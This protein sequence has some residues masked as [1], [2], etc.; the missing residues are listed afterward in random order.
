[1]VGEVKV[2]G[3]ITIFK[4][5]IPERYHPQASLIYFI[6]CSLWSIWYIGNKFICPCCNGHFRKFLP[7]GI[8]QRQNAQCPRCGSLVRH[9]LLW[10]YLK[11]KTNFF[12]DSLKVL[13]IAPTE[14][15]TLEALEMLYIE[16]E[17]AV[18]ASKN[19]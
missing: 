17:K 9:R 5:I 8:K 14:D 10:L 15:I 4:K 2:M 13:D 7:Y 16:I 3:L 18:K 1:M 11:N 6:L 19:K 12:K